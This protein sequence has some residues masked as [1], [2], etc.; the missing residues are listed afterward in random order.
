MF[1]LMDTKTPACSQI[2][3][4]FIPSKR[5]DCEDGFM[6]LKKSVVLLRSRDVAQF[7]LKEGLSFNGKLTCSGDL[8]GGEDL[9]RSLAPSPLE[10]E[11]QA[12]AA[13]ALT[14]LML[15]TS[16]VQPRGSYV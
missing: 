15:P 16:A 8:S 4:T 10:R 3:S 13:H 5:A 1:T 6:T 12:A 14:L 9:A 7:F 2:Y 11:V